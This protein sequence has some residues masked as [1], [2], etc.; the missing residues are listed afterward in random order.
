MKTRNSGPKAADRISAHQQEPETDRTPANWL[1]ELLTPQ[2]A[3]IG[4]ELNAIVD[5]LTAD[6]LAHIGANL[7][8]QAA[9]RRR[10]ITEDDAHAAVKGALLTAAWK[11]SQFA[12]GGRVRIATANLVGYRGLH[13]EQVTDAMTNVAMELCPHPLV[14]HEA[15]KMGCVDGIAIRE[16]VS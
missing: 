13:P 11:L 3:T 6:Q 16:G 10:T 5:R 15:V 12:D 7:T 2:P 14:A 1:D 4:E 9:E 8:A